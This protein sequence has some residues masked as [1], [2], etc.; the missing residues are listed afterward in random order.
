MHGLLQFLRDNSNLIS[1]KKD[2]DIIYFNFEKVFDKVSH[3]QLILQLS[4]LGFN[5]YLTVKN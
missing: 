5:S 3:E 1:F 4:Q 2:I